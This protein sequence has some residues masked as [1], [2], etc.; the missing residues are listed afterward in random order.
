MQ[1]ETVTTESSHGRM[2]SMCRTLTGC[3]SELGTSV[4]A[5][6]SCSIYSYS[7]ILGHGKT[8]K[9]CSFLMFWE[10]Y[11]PP[12]V[13]H[14]VRRGCSRGEESVSLYLTDRIDPRWR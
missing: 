14:V 1:D 6:Q 4:H 9:T 8:L 10:F 11:L 13:E 2:G 3:H 5:L 12:I 7:R